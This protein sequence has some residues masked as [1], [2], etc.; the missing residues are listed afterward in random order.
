MAGEG[1][2]EGMA[3]RAKGTQALY[4][5]LP[6]ALFKAVKAEAMRQDMKLVQVVKQALTMW[7]EEGQGYDGDDHDG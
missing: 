7:L 3:M 5:E 4:A 6:T 1:D 2:R